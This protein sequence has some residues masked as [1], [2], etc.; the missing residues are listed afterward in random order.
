MAGYFLGVHAR[1]LSLPTP[2][3]SLAAQQLLERYSWPGNTRELESVIHFALLVCGEVI[4]SEHLELAPGGRP[5]P[6]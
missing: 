6:G 1:R 3:L 2:T 4:E 5:T